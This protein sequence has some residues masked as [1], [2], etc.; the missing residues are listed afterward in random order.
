MGTDKKNRVGSTEML[1]DK[2]SIPDLKHLLSDVEQK[3]G[4]AVSFESL[5][6]LDEI[7][8]IQDDFSSA[9]GV[10]SIITR[11]DGTPL[12]TP[13][14]F[15]R[16]CSDVI[17]KTE[18][19]CANCYKSDA[20]IGR[21]NPAGPIVQQ[22]MSGGLWY[23][24]ANITVDGQHIANW[25]IG[26]VRDKTQ[27]D[28]VMRA[29][30][31]TIGADESSFMAAFK[32]VPAMTRERFSAIAKA[33]FTIAN[34]LSE[35]AF[36][37][38]Q[39]Q[40]AIVELQV[41]QKNLQESE[42]YNKTLFADAHHALVVMDPVT[43]T[44][45]DCNK[46]ALDIYRLPSRDALIGLTPL[47]VS[48]P[49]QYDGADSKVAVRDHVNQ[50]LAK[51][52]HVFEWRHQRMD[53]QEWDAE[54][55]LACFEYGARTL[56]Q[57]TLQ[58]ITERRKTGEA[59]RASEE[60]LSVTLHSIGDAV[61]ATD[62]SG[63]ISRMN[64]TAERLSGW[65]LADALGR[66]LV[67]IFHIVNAETREPVPD[68][69]QVVM[70]HGQVVGL[71]NHTVLLARDG[72]EYQIADSAAPIRSAGGE[73]LGVV[74]V[75]S[76]VSEQYRAEQAL[77]DSEKRFK[78]LH[79]ASF[80]GISIHEKGVI[81]DCNQGLSNLTGFDKHELVGMDGLE[82]IAPEWRDE[83]RRNIGSGF[84]THYE[85]EGLRKDGTRYPM[86][87]QG[88]NIPY[89]GR[90]VRVTEFRDTTKEKRA[91]ES[92]RK[93][94]ALHR[95][96]MA[97]IGDVIVI[98]DKNGINTFKSANIEK[99]F[100]WKPEE[101]VG[102]STWANVHPDDLE[103]T[104]EFYERLLD[105]PNASGTAECR[106]LC[107]GGSYRWI[108]TT[109]TNLLHDPDI[110]GLLG[111]YHDIT[112]R[113]QVLEA[114][115]NSE[116]KYRSLLNNLSSGVV[117]HNPDTSVF[118]SN[119]ASCSLLGLSKDQMQG[120]TAVDTGWCFLHEDGTPML[121]KDYPVN[122]VIASG[123]KYQDHVIGVRRADRSEPAWMLCNAYPM[124]DEDGTILQVVATFADITERK[125]AEASLS[126]S[127]SLTNAAL[128]STA[129]GI[130]IVG[131][132][133]KIARW[134]QRFVDLWKV[135]E[136]LLDTT[137]DDPVLSHVTAQMADPEAF[138]TK[139][140]ELNESPGA[141]SL[142]TLV[143]VDGR[144]VERYSQPQMIGKDVVGR[145]WSFRDITERKRAE[146]KIN[147]LAY[148]DQLTD[149]PNRTLLQ[150]RLK[151]AMAS[152]TRSGNFGALLL[153]DLDYFKTLNDTLGHDMGDLLLKQVAR[154]LT[155]C[156]REEDTVSRL[157]GDEFIVMLVNLSENR[158]EAAS[159]V[160][161]IGSKITAALNKSYDL[162]EVSYDITPS[163]GAN[164]FL[165]QHT[166]ID[167]LLKQ[168]DLAMYK[169]KNA[170]RNAL[171]FF[172]PDMASD[173][174]KRASLD[175]DLREAIH[176]NQY[177]LH[178]QAQVA[179]NRVTGAEVLLR[180]QHPSRGLVFPGEFISVIEE[181]GLILSVGQW[182]LESAC[183][184]LADWARQPEMSQLSIAVNISARQFNQED[185][186]NQVL[187][188]L[189]YSGANPQRLKLELT[190]S[191]LVN[192]VED[193]IGKMS[194]LKSKGVG[195]SLD[196]FGTGYSSLAYLKRLPLDQLKIDQSFV[197]DILIDAN[198]A[199]IAKMIVVLAESMGLAVIAEGVET[200]A[201][202]NTLA[203]LGCHAYQGYFFS[204]PL[205]LS[206]FEA[207]VKQA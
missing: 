163:I 66:P 93:T 89:Q 83:V 112:E 55:H 147:H 12:T 85:A 38:L 176:K 46:A 197:R 58:D 14:N 157:G 206:E 61:I 180:W 67:E 110:Q 34:Q 199:A 13:S 52:S 164:V 175:N 168:A 194:A 121:L 5:F 169:A 21:H 196:D 203:Q 179:G 77:R 37:S 149:L 42:T 3:A 43:T 19:G 172:D 65:V 80:G 139:V 192:N 25:L 101:L 146:E 165:G 51:G 97:N 177:L 111:N 102:R 69:V 35:K 195:F 23:A 187:T 161:L 132:N 189:D 178:Y 152:S 64:A 145:F 81:L 62:A 24:G 141:S 138:L 151:Q 154:R 1:S 82:L 134:N 159:Q 17:R 201:E 198:D 47:D 136:E 107:K 167:T 186:V 115:R 59:L 122:Q 185:F 75:F 39:Q 94:E 131:R 56:L 130:L 124:F 71:A 91:E 140:V 60:N 119:A 191:L 160:E 120:K 15:T 20:A 79:D 142:D 57:F 137:I 74:L 182:V 155:E 63:R 40:A 143:L 6:Q 113:K 92:A 100:G 31:R 144:V 123:E 9:T 108:E 204:R 170:G 32:E 109:V 2:L 78:A 135:P 200:E 162:R 156:V 116:E 36:L 16:L 205:P 29:Y 193:I 188:A 126:Y 28:E 95:K 76:D 133:G 30:A 129:D 10:A 84:E 99:W 114:L 174:L 118:L 153:I 7:Q 4:S 50:A 98:I 166:D 27:T 106:Y 88:K 105:V 48:A 26:Q 22:C 202:K 125:L 87:I 184:Q 33:L 173:V 103:A 148:F 104:Q 171:R 49:F 44:F 128:E 11:P 207:F 53:G 127:V 183:K 158:N 181:T 73:I 45:I 150:D 190:E 68:P 96:M 70:A 8:R 72:K 90:S 117:V 41:L 54:V 18:K 86:S